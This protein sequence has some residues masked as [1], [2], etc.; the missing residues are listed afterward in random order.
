M[1]STSRAAS[2]LALAG[3]TLLAFLVRALPFADFLHR[4]VVAFAP[5]DAM[6]HVRR[7]YW[8]FVGWPSVLAF[9]PYVN[10]PDGAPVPWSPLPDVLAGTIARIVA[11]DDAGFALVLAWW[12]PAVG[13]LGAIPVWLLAREVASRAVATAAVAFYALLPISVLYGRFANPDHHVAVAA[14]GA[15]VL[16]ACVRLAR[17]GL[18]RDRALAVRSA[19]AL[20]VARAALLLTW[21]GSLLYLAFAEASVLLAGVLGRRRAL[22]AAHAASALATLVL[23]APIVAA[24]PEPLGGPYSSIA[25]SRLHL[26]AIAAV[27]ATAAAGWLHARRAPDASPVA[28]AGALAL[29]ALVFAALLALAPAVR[30]GLEPAFRFL[31]MTD[32]AGSRTAEQFPLFGGGGGAIG[33]AGASAASGPLLVWAGYA[34]LLPL[35]PFAFVLHAR[36]GAPPERRAATWM[37][38]GWSAVFAALAIAQRRYGNDL[39]AAASVGFALGGAHLARALASALERAGQRAPRARLAAGAAVALAGLALY[40]PAIGALY[41]PWAR[42]ALAHARSEPASPPRNAA[43]AVT[44]FASAVRAATPETSGFARADGAPEYGI[45]AHANLGHALQWVARRATP[46]DPFWEYIGPANWNRAFELLATSDE[47]RAVALAREL[48]ARYVVASRGLRR[49]GMSERLHTD[50]GAPR[51]D[52]PALAHFRLVAEGPKGG[53]GLQDMFGGRAAPDAVPYKL[54]EVVEGAV[55]EVAAPPS[56]RV[57]VAVDVATPTGRRFAWRSATAAGADGVARLRVPYATG[58]PPADAPSPGAAARA[59]GPVRVRV[60]GVDAG[61]VDVPERAVLGGERIPLA[62][63]ARAAASGAN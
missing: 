44:Q 21:H 50:D 7:A 58:S 36:R 34:L 57:E 53:V 27:L 9:D 13:A 42:R 54:F 10:Y 18:E 4:G 31:T 19:L 45:V 60:D 28:R 46:T 17:P 43:W 48:R 14:V 16:L 41:L 37:L 61:G 8:T 1:A 59:E 39:A 20:G 26:L 49:G 33:R 51:G 52:A 2:A 32:A 35:L 23:V 22:F 40:A 56:S 24:L 29:G 11:R 12:P 3:A 63:A 38:A 30:A 62:P 55:L 47:A 15:C 25:L 6:Y 5:A